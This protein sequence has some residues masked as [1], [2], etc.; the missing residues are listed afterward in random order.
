MHADIVAAC[1]YDEFGHSG[2]YLS[3]F[4]FFFLSCHE[5][6]EEQNLN[7]GQKSMDQPPKARGSPKR[8]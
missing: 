5:L 2:D 7:K 8:A 3:Q 1:L 4:S 6:T